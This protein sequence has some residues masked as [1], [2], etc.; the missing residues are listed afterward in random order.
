VDESAIGGDVW[1]VTMSEPNCVVL[2]RPRWRIEKGAS[3]GPTEVLRADRAIRDALGIAHRGGGMKQPWVTGT[4][5]GPGSD[6]ELIYELEVE[7]V[8][9][10]EMFVA[11]ERPDLYRVELNG[12]AIAS[13][14]GFYTDRSLRKLAVDPALVRKG[15]NVLRLTTRYGAAHPGLEI[16]YLLGTFGVRLENDT[17]VVAGAIEK[18]ALGSVTTQGLPFY[19]GNLTY[20]ATAPDAPKPD[21]RYF[22]RVPAYAGVA[23]RVL[24]D[25]VPAGVA[26]W[27]PHEVEITRLLKAG[28]EIGIEILGHRRNS[29][30]PHHHKLLHPHWTGPGEF[31]AQGEWWRE[32]YGIVAMG[33]MERPVLV[34][35]AC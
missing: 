35:D 9:R 4:T 13:D 2:D 3:G 12:H 7:I 23:V 32:G 21:H 20:R 6:L 1:S 14:A 33:L 31:V 19:S 24:V 10:G 16:V 15:T 28:A 34:T 26:A 29:H 27:A 17:P 8:P 30:G 5:S 22:V 11:I 25:G 18:L